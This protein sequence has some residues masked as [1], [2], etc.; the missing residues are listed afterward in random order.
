MGKN[1]KGNG[2]AEKGI[3]DSFKEGNFNKWGTVSK[4]E[5][6]SEFQRRMENARMLADLRILQTALEKHLLEKNNSLPIV[7]TGL[8]VDSWDGP[9]FSLEQGLKDY[10]PHGFREYSFNNY[11]PVVYCWNN[12][13]Y[14]LATILR[15]SSD[16]SEILKQNKISSYKFQNKFQKCIISTDGSLT[17]VPVCGEN[18]VLGKETNVPV[19]CL[20]N[21]Q[22]QYGENLIVDSDRD[23]LPDEAEINIYHTDPHNP[24]TDGDGYLDGVEVNNGYNPKGKGRL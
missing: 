15:K 10:F 8:N 6:Q 7:K 21:L 3:A 12:N 13:R 5:N 22:Q 2:G 9:E 24:D 11:S 23:G 1:N 18:G 17:D 14:L 20:E 16:Y 4:E 19:Y